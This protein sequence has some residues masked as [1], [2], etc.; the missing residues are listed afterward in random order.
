MDVVKKIESFGSQ[1]GKPT[2]KVVFQPTRTTGVP[3]LTPILYADH[4]RQVRH[5]LNVGRSEKEVKG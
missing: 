2:Q 4:H 1:T 3:F 5:A